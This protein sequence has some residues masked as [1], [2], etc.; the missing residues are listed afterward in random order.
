MSKSNKT[1]GRS[2]P[3]PYDGFP[4]SAHVHT[5]RWY[6][7][8]AGRRHYFGRLDD[9]KA[10]MALYEHQAPYLVEGRTPPP[11]GREGD[12]RNV[13]GVIN[14]FLHA[15]RRAVD[16]GEM[17]ERSWA[18]YHNVGE[19]IVKTLGRHRDIDTLTPDDFGKLRGAISRTR[20][21]VTVGNLITRCRSI[22]KF[23]VEEGITDRAVRYGTQFSKPKRRSIRVDR[24]SKP[25]K[26]F[27]VE[28]VHAL[29]AGADVPLR[30][31]ILLAVNAG[32]GN[33]DLSNLTTDDIDL[34]AGVVSLYRHKTGADR[35][36]VLWP[37][38]IA[39]V[40]VAIQTRPDAADPQHADRVFITTHG[41]EWVRTEVH[42]DTTRAG[43]QRPRVVR[44]DNVAQRFNT[45]LDK[46][47]VSKGGR[48]F[49]TLRHTFRTIADAHPDR[50]AVDLV[51]G[52]ENAAD[53][54]TEY[55]DALS[56]NDERLQAVADHV[57]QWLFGKPA[58]RS[59]GKG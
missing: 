6:K 53:M 19:M 51:M 25:R 15:K 14:A 55:V 4:L 12:P 58:K 22:F 2:Y 56:V 1:T 47:K 18:E 11:P 49:Y 46:A 38:T 27:T 40:R 30:A 28:E 35:R 34:G 24:R 42:T 50:P 23:A 29:L 31:M 36:A 3:K 7:T 33:S 17:T 20:S 59:R 44:S 10:A 8:I 39:A 26:L 48:G 43:T 32:L 57:H 37:E 45:L 16:A 9:W 13:A 41:R 21:P 52:H 54:R 5:N